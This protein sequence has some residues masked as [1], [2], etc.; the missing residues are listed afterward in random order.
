MAPEMID[1]NPGARVEIE[2]ATS[3]KA[4]WINIDGICRMR[5]NAPKELVI[6]NL[7]TMR[8]P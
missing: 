1:V 5:I 7:S 8:K 4:I 3:A 2:M 6:T